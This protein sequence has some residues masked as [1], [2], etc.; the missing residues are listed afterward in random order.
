MARVRH[1]LIHYA[2]NRIMLSRRGTPSYGVER[3]DLISP[4]PARTDERAEPAEG[5]LTGWSCRS[6]DSVRQRID[7]FAL[8][9]RRGDANTAGLI[10]PKQFTCAHGPT[11]G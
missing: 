10:D 6:G 9:R 1:S 4:W 7:L 2:A 11:F 8:K 5:L 3:N